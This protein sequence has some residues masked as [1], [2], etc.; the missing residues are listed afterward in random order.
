MEARRCG[1]PT[2][3]GKP[4]QACRGAGLGRAGGRAVA[5][6]PPPGGGSAHA[7]TVPSATTSAAIAEAH[8]KAARP[9]ARITS[10]PDAPK[11][12]TALLSPR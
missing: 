4:C 2:K 3:S 9:P 8:S 10:G 6:G 11:R 1:R 5:G 12:T 7:G